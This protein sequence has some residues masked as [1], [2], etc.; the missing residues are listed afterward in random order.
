MSS[1]LTVVPNFEDA[2]RWM[3]FSRTALLR[4][5]VP[6]KV[7]A[8]SDRCSCILLEERITVFYLAEGFQE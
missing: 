5:S 1:R 8:C 6:G 7:I 4:H 3:R 2:G